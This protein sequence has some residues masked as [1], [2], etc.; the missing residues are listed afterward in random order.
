MGLSIF[1]EKTTE[2]SLKSLADFMPTGVPFEEKNIKEA[3]FF[4]ILRGNA[5]E[6]DRVDGKMNEISSEHDPRETHFANAMSAD[7]WTWIMDELNRLVDEIDYVREVHGPTILQ[8]GVMLYQ[9][10]GLSSK[11]AHENYLRTLA[12]QHWEDEH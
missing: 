6:I 10:R 8:H 1:A 9:F 11:I 5:L 2:E 7:G 3:V 4:K 12:Y